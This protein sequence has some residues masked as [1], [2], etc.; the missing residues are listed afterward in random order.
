MRPSILFTLSLFPL[1]GIG[2]D[3]T[4][5]NG[6]EVALMHYATRYNTDFER[7]EAY[8][9]FLGVLV[10]QGGDSDFYMLPDSAKSRVP[11]DVELLMEAD[12]LFRVVKQPDEDRLFFSDIGIDGRVRHYRDSLHPMVWKLLPERRTIGDLECEKAVTVFRGRNYT[13]W[14]A[15]SIPIANGPWKLGGLPGLI[16]EAYEDNMDMH[17]MLTGI[18]FQ[19]A[20]GGEKPGSNHAQDIPGYSAFIDYWKK[21][22]NMLR[23]SVGA[24]E[25][26]DC[27]SCHVN[28]K[29][30]FYS[31]EKVDTL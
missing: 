25:S 19:K 10:C 1:C 30:R 6:E 23:G 16:V 21:A 24:R 13:A 17:F 9:H 26:P 31:W 14:Y 20:Q 15:V 8:R 7:G 11:D 12:T 29:V 4:G 5:H 22:V 28:T 27:V 2:Q 18:R 3:S